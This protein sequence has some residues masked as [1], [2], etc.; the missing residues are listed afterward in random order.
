MS[1][2]QI[3]GALA[4][5]GLA[6]GCAPVEA[7]PADAPAKP[8]VV[9]AEARDPA[10]DWRN[11]ASAEDAD[12]LARMPAE[13]SAGLAAIRSAAG[14]RLLK[15]QGALLDPKASLPHPAPPPGSYR[16]RVWRM[17]AAAGR[18]SGLVA[19]KPFFCHVGGGETLLTFTKQTG[20]DRPGGRLWAD[21]DTRLVFLGGLATGSEEM[22]PAYGEDPKRDLI[23]TLERV[24]D[25]RWRITL[26][27]PVPESRL[28][29]IELVPV[30]EPMAEEPA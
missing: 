25:F 11:I 8:A 30:V 23:G 24:E 4:A 5:A 26:V 2:R 3:F 21:G 16:C 17:P 1:G 13:W 18:G 6:A 19:Y 15:G 22:P 29:V 9:I 7:P 20:S 12:L 28:D 14:R 10:L 27:R